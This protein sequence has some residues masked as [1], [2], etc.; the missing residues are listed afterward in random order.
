MNLVLNSRTR[1][2]M[3]A[4][5]PDDESLAAGLLLQQATTARASVRIVYATDGED[6][7][8]P[9]RFFEKRWHLDEVDRARWGKRRRKEAI[10]ALSMLGLSGAHARFLGLPDQGITSLLLRDAG[11]AVARIKQTIIDWSPTLL[12]VPSILDAHPDHSALAV[13]IQFA[14][15]DIPARLNSFV[16][17]CYL[18]HGKHKKFPFQVVISPGND[19]ETITKRQA[20]AQH[21]TQMRFSRRRFMAYAR[22]IEHFQLAARVPVIPMKSIALTARNPTEVRLRVFFR[23]LST[24]RAFFY[25]SGYGRRGVPVSVCLPLPEWDARL[26]MIDGRSSRRIGVTN[27]RRG[28]LTGEL[29]F[30]TT[31]FD[32]NRPLFAKVRHSHRFFDHGWIEIPS[33]P[34]A[35]TVSPPPTYVAASAQPEDL[36]PVG[37]FWS[38]GS[39]FTPPASETLEQRK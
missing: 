26:Q 29:T 10:A 11:K 28:P 36:D 5:H 20:I 8:W 38:G 7:P 9:Q 34:M 23:L 1:L 13:L 17:L 35:K 6:N 37:I 14:V 15:G 31:E 24:K 3:I 27:Y 39:G 33:L 12:L 25:L 16:L 18:V 19:H 2:M 4:P 30:S 21:H 22:R 32:T